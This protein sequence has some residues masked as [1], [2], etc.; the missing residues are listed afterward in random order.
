MEKRKNLG[1]TLIA[2][3]ITII[4]MLIL[5]GATIQVLTS[6][7]LFST[8]K[9]AGETYKEEEEKEVMKLAFANALTESIVNN[10]RVSRTI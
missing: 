10:K 5:A 2:L 3:I 1:I 7:K 4:V 9:Q 8:A 6:T